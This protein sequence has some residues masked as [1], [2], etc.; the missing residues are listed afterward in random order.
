MLRHL[1]ES[2]LLHLD[3]V[4]LSLSSIQ[5]IVFLFLS[6]VGYRAPVHASTRNLE[7]QF[8]PLAVPGF[9]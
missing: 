6:D 2:S 4:F 9:Y 8:L 5:S 7:C 3:C 1:R